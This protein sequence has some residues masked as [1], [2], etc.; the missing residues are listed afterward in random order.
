MG[1]SSRPSSF[2]GDLIAI[3][4]TGN[5]GTVLQHEDQ[6]V[7][8]ISQPDPDGCKLGHHTAAG[9]NTDHTTDGGC[10]WCRLVDVAFC[11]SVYDA[12]VNA[13]KAPNPLYTCDF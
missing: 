2:R 4:T 3:G 11:T 6:A 7:Y 13:P 12:K 1:G 9:C 5:H 8:N 10:V